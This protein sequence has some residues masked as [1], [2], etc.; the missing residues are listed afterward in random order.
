[1]HILSGIPNRAVALT[2]QQIGWDD[3][4]PL[5]YAVMTERLGPDSDF[6]DYRDAVL[7]ECAARLSEASCALVEGAFSQVGL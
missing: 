5:F 4:E 2:I 6:A 1:V 7:A 3:A